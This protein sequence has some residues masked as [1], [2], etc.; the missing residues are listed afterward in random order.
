MIICLCLIQAF[1]IV[2]I[3]IKQEAV[4]SIT[5]ELDCQVYNFIIGVE[6]GDQQWRKLKQTQ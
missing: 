1:L 6:R 4:F 5:K 2:M 3:E